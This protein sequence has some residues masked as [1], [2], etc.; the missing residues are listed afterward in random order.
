MSKNG[1]DNL[2]NS[3]EKGPI[4]GFFKMAMIAVVCILITLASLWVISPF[5]KGS[6]LVNKVVD[7][8]SRLAD[9][10]WFH[11]QF[12]G[13]KS[14]DSKIIGAKTA[15]SEYLE[16]LGDRGSWGR[17]DKIEIARLNSIKIGLI[18]QINDSVAEYNARSKMINRNWVKPD[19]IPYQILVLEN[20]KANFNY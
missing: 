15:Y 19:G 10:E 18:Q 4:T 1:W 12:E 3:L 5:F 2:E 16:L 6:E 8:D 17:E 13:I 20:G 7:V 14:L 11:N 9:Y